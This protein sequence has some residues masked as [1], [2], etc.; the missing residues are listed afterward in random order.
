[1]SSPIISLVRICIFYMIFEKN[2]ENNFLLIIEKKWEFN[3]YFLNHGK[4]TYHAN[5][6]I[7]FQNLH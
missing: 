6:D 4:V 2:D 7:H 3:K 1:M 5:F